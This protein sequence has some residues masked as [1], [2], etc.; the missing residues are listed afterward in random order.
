MVV[1]VQNTDKMNQA[2]VCILTSGRGTR[3]GEFSEI[4]NKA[5][6]PIDNQAVISHIIKQFP[7]D[8]KFVISLGFKADQVRNYLDIAH[9]ENDIE[10]VVVDKFEGEGTGPGYS[11]AC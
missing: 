9:A 7:S 8:T 1:S 2:V 6:L 5:I 3:M 10:Y 4:A 11:L